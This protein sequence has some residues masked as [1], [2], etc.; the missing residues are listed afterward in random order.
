MIHTE[1]SS[2]DIVG[3]QAS[4]SGIEHRTCFFHCR[5]TKYYVIATETLSQKFCLYFIFEYV[6]STIILK[7][8]ILY[9]IILYYIILYYIILYY[10]ILYYIIL[11]YIIL[12]F[13]LYYNN[14][15]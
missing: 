2:T 7:Y 4:L 9:Y 1:Q 10:I 5:M 8:I 13:I 6:F 12:Y 11:Y 14:M 3:R 15:T